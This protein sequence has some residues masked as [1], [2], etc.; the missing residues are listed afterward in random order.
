M[1]S[2]NTP[3]RKARRSSSSRFSSEVPRCGRA[4]R[5]GLEL[6]EERLCPSTLYDYD[7]IAQSGTNNLLGLGNGPSINDAGEVAFVGRFT[8]GDDIFVGHGGGPQ[9]ISHTADTRK[10]FR[11]AVQINNA[12]QIVAVNR[13]S[14]VSDGTTSFPP[15][16]FLQLW[17]AANGTF[18]QVDHAGSNGDTYTLIFALASVNNLN[19]TSYV[20]SDLKTVFLQRGPGES[21]DSFPS[22]EPYL[23]PMIA[24]DGKVVARAGSNLN[25]PITLYDP[26]YSFPII[27]ASSADFTRLG[28]GAGISDDGSVVA[29]YGELDPTAAT[30]LGLTPGPGIFASIADGSSRDL[31][32]VAGVAGNGYLDPGEKWVDP[33]GNGRVDPGED[34]GPFA[35]FNPDLR[36]AARAAGT[37]LS[38]IVYIATGADGT[39]G[40]YTSDLLSAGDG[41]DRTINADAPSLVADTHTPLHLEDQDV[42]LTGFNLYDPINAKGQVAF[43]ATTA[44][45]GQVI[46]RANPERAPVLLVPGIVGSF[47]RPD[48]FHYWLTHRGLAPGE[49]QIDPLLRVYDDL[50][51]TLENEGYVQGTDLFVATYDWR[52]PLAPLDLAN[53]DADPTNDHFEGRITGFTATDITNGD[54]RYGVDY[55]GYWLRLATESWHNQHPNTPLQDVD[56]IAHSMGG[57]LTRCYIQSDAYEQPFNASF[58]TANL[59]GIDNFIMLGVPNQGASK[60]WNPLHDNFINDLSFRLVLSK[61]IKAAWK[62]QLTGESLLGPTPGDSI[63]LEPDPLVF[64]HKYLPSMRGL[65]ATYPFLDYGDGDPVTVNGLPTERNNLLLDLNAGLGTVAGPSGDPNSFADRVG[66]VRIV[67]GTNG[68]TTP[69]IVEEHHGPDGTGGI[70]P[71]KSL[72]KARDPNANETW[73]LDV[74][75]R[76]AVGFVQKNGDGTVPLVSAIGQFQE[77]GRV[78]FFPFT[79]RSYFV[80][81]NTDG[82]VSHTGLVSN[83]D[84]QKMILGS[85]GI[86]PEDSLVH[87]GYLRDGAVIDPVKSLFTAWSLMLDP[88][89][90]VLVDADGKRLGYT[91]QGPVT[92]IPNS[93]YFGGSDGIGWVFGPLK[94]TPQVQLSGLGQ[95]YDVEVAGSEP[96]RAAEVEVSGS[97]AVGQTQAQNVTLLPPFNVAPQLQPIVAQCTA[98]GRP[99]ALQV[100]A[101]DVNQDTLAYS[102]DPG[103]PAGAAIDAHTGL[104]TWTPAA[105]Q[106]LGGYSIT[107]RVTDNGT[108]VL[109]A[110]TT[111]TVTLKPAVAVGAPDP[112]FGSDGQVTADF[113]SPGYG[114]YT[115]I[116]A[117][118]SDGKLLQAGPGVYGIVLARYLP[119][120]HLDPTFGR[121]GWASEAIVSPGDAIDPLALIV[122]PDGRILLICDTHDAK[123]TFVRFNSDGSLDTT[124][125]SGGVVTGPGNQ[126]T[127]RDRVT[128]LPDGKI[129][130]TGSGRLPDNSHALTLSRYNPDG[131]L[132]ASFGTG[133]VAST[134]FSQVA[135]AEGIALQSDGR[136]VVAAYVDLTDDFVVLRFNADGSPDPT[137]GQAG[138]VRTDFAPYTIVDGAGAVAVQLDGKIVVAGRTDEEGAG[139]GDFIVSDFAVIR[140]NPDGSLDTSFGNGGKARAGISGLDDHATAVALQ[141]DGKI[142][143]AGNS[144]RLIPTSPGSADATISSDFAAARFLANGSVDTTFGTGGVV[145]TDLGDDDR[146]AGLALQPGGQIVLAGETSSRATRTDFALV[147][148]TPDGSLDA[149]FAGEGKDLID[150]TASGQDMAAALVRQSDGKI[151]VAGST[152]GRVTYEDDFALLR[153]NADGSPDASFGKGGKLVN[154][155]S[156][157]TS[158]PITALAVQ[159]DGKVITAGAGLV[160]I[161]TNGGSGFVV[162]RYNAN[163]TVDRTF[164]NRGI[165]LFTSSSASFNPFAVAGVVLQADGKIVVAG[166]AQV[167]GYWEGQDGRFDRDIVLVRYNPDGSADTTFGDGGMVDL[168]FVPNPGFGNW[169]DDTAVAVRLQLDGKIVV[170]G[171]E[172]MLY[173]NGN[174]FALARFNSD[175]SL[176]TTFGDHGLV[177]TDLGYGTDFENFRDNQSD[178]PAG[179]VLQPDGKVIVGGTSGGDF[180]LARYNANGSLD[181]DFGSWGVIET[182]LPQGNAQAGGIDR[183]AD[184]KLVLAGSVGGNDVVLRYNADGTLDETFGQGGVSTFAFHAGNDTAAGVLVQSDGTILLAGTTSSHDTRADFALA[185]LWGGVPSS[186]AAAQVGFSAATYAI[187]EDGGNAVITVTRTGDTGGTVSVSYFMGEGNARP[188]IDYTPT[189]GTLV[190]GPGETSKT[191]SVAVGNDQQ[192]GVDR[193]VN[194]HMGAAQGGTTLATAAI[195]T[196]RISEVQPFPGPGPSPTPQ[197]VRDVTGMVSI[198]RRKTTSTRRQTLIVQ[199]VSGAPLTG[200]VVLVLDGLPRKVQLTNASGVTRQHLPNGSPFLDLGPLGPG[201]KATVVLQF[202]ASRNARPRFSMRVLMGDDAI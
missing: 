161:T 40:V 167:N 97:L 114:S 200:R 170:A 35:S 169:S 99:L 157:P 163:G 27:I 44:N 53:T 10:T 89:E 135:Y 100:T 88:V 178:V 160:G 150:F 37:Q 61:V 3:A 17:N 192:P 7:L 122:R 102:L 43:W 26:A 119:D 138:Q 19:Q 113:L 172:S 55:L 13:I 5:P 86:A 159:P 131:S 77:D 117:T 41:Q 145:R 146:V 186:V 96:T 132:D 36:V 46:V 70:Y 153:F 76:N 115:G 21:I 47:P 104:I 24:D 126:L 32:R 85:L 147:R 116:V 156:L 34:R 92:E 9:Q 164:G 111:F 91:S 202:R 130:V 29:F 199:N 69:T 8:Q 177:L 62:V 82:N 80:A 118:Q 95:N 75:K 79:H 58:G 18:Q 112:C 57:L 175:G 31:I 174:D 140:Y 59:P 136:I 144:E 133:G 28:T 141:A 73:Y 48:N 197:P 38:T 143:V 139:T 134:A 106:A 107:V 196:L 54:F 142:V 52:L 193:L 30:R 4:F 81:G 173:V 108:P 171:K 179:F 148:Y 195:A 84:V 15:T 65:L 129:V 120:G 63:Q 201:A 149:S 188:G 83:P 154:D 166:T 16:Y 162:S 198:R 110:S 66:Q 49:M 11:E 127:G 121:G 101:G 109:S 20:G 137:F 33:N 23:R 74:P 194:L 176:D 123:I 90:G 71:F 51:K 165:V 72:W 94:G 187:R 42:T 125:G 14:G 39:T 103:A 158:A 45:G 128:V 184:G 60:D 191:F 155:W 98:V 87:T 68:D 67:Y 56:V 151:L 183:Q 93:V 181:T 2:P 182:H 190:F 105:G 189:S 50:I 152:R 64:L 78:E 12:G 22:P 1:S 6:L 180:A 25:D 185:R 124:F 168:N